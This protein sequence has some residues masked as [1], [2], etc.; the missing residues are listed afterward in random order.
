[1]IKQGKAHAFS[2]LGFNEGTYMRLAQG[3]ERQGFTTDFFVVVSQHGIAPW[4]P[5]MVE[6][7][8][9]DYYLI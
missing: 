8:Q 1:M 2:K 4:S 5:N 6:Q 9:D 7:V 3:V